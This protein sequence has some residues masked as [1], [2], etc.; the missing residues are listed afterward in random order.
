MGAAREIEVVG[1]EHERGPLLTVEFLHEFHHGRA[2]TRVEVSGGLVG[3]QDSRTVRKGPRQRD[4]LLLPTR[5]LRRVVVE[6]V[7]E[8]DSFQKHSSAVPVV[9]GTFAAH[10]L[11]RHEN[12]LEGGE[13][14]QEVER[15]EDKAYVSGSK[16]GSTVLG[17]GEEVF[18]GQEDPARGGFIEPCEQSQQRGLSRT[19]R[20]HDGDEALGLDRQ[21]DSFE[22][23]QWPPPASIGLH[24]IFGDDHMRFRVKARATV[25]ILAIFALT[26]CGGDG[27]PESGMRSGNV[28]AQA[29]VGD[30]DA[31]TT[32]VVAVPS[33]AANGRVDGPRVVFLG[34]SLTA[35][36]G[37]R[38]AAD[39]WPER[40][41]D[42]ADSAGLPIQVVNA[43]RSGD[44]S[45]GGLAR[46]DWALSEPVDLLVVELGANDGLRGQSTDALEANLSEVIDQTRARWP[47]AAILLV[48][49]EAPTNLGAEYTE[50]FR[51]VYR[52]VARDKAV[53]LV[54]FLLD[55]VAG[56]PELNQPDRI[57]PTA[58]GHRRAALTVWPYFEPLLRDT[59]AG[60]P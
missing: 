33:G 15:L 39:R 49:M 45:A 17:Q 20:A 19:G 40:L 14:G 9:G 4:A 26:G 13:R 22:H 51:A 44:T 43:G 16:P 53:A 21:I 1:H 31:D 3:K 46:L 32:G 50:R 52:E 57:H 58:E 10:Q 48:G 59:T 29:G 38:S 42:M 28:E 35:G 8:T 54:P 60:T 56:V 5:K 18:S 27:A 37:L 55:G 12:V 47:D 2:G 36:L 6:T 34:T 30:R 7:A 23:G 11:E 41:G 24:K 25:A